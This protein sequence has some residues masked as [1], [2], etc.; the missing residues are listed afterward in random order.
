MSKSLSRYVPKLAAILGVDS[1]TLSIC[2]DE[3]GILKVATLLHLKVSSHTLYL[4]HVIYAVVMLPGLF[5]K[6]I[7]NRHTGCAGRRG[8]GFNSYILTEVQEFNARRASM[9]GSGLDFRC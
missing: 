4:F 7:T 5:W 2:S 9:R 3:V 6:M 8:L 1:N